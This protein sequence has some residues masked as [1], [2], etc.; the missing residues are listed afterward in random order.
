[1]FDD[2]FYRFNESFDSNLTNY[3]SFDVH[4]DYVLRF[5][6]DGW[7]TS[8]PDGQ[9]LLAAIDAIGPLLGQTGD[10]EVY[11]AKGFC[12]Q[13]VPMGEEVGFYSPSWYSMPWGSG[14][15]DKLNA[16]DGTWLVDMVF[17]PKVASTSWTS[18]E[19]WTQILA[20]SLPG[21][22]GRPRVQ[23][24]G[25]ITLDP[26]VQFDQD[27]YYAYVEALTFWSARQAFWEFTKGVE[28]RTDGTFNTTRRAINKAPQL[29]WNMSS[30]NQLGQD[31][32]G[33]AKGSAFRPY[34]LEPL[35]VAGTITPGTVPGGSEVVVPLDP[36]TGQP[37]A[38]VVT[39][40]TLPTSYKVGGAVAG[41][42]LA[43]F[44]GWAMDRLRS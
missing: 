33:L 20:G 4:Y 11:E 44:L 21:S 15:T 16:G 10:L 23:A 31:G 17:R 9:R 37:A 26:Q 6:V 14:Y 1:M 2:Q 18:V 30:L 32:F 28:E 35:A 29:A 8:M 43:T 13:K 40:R 12:F 5:V 39:W 27:V 42:A 3:T 25:L 38:A 24:A 7:E 41:V 19:K 34:T 36:Q 22:R